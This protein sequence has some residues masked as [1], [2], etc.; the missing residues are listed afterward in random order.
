MV[1]GNKPL[2]VGVSLMKGGW[3]PGKGGSKK[4]F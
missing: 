3:L 2:R 1:H 4:G